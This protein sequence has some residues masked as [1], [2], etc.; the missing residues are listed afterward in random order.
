MCG[1]RLLQTVIFSSI[2]GSSPRV[3]GTLALFSPRFLSPR[4]IPACA[5]N[6][7]QAYKGYA[8][9]SVHPRVCGERSCRIINGLFENGSSPRV[10]GTP[11]QLLSGLIALRF[12]PACAGNAI[13]IICDRLRLSVHPRVC[14]ERNRFIGY[15]LNPRGSSPRV[16]GTRLHKLIQSNHVRFIPACAGNALPSNSFQVQRS[17][18]PRVCGERP[19]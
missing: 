18:H 14:G 12:I 16:R 11:A 5:G 13:T 10:R 8:K 9:H 2:S 3:R 17:V 19:V 1:E 6:A 7:R 15:G 4:F